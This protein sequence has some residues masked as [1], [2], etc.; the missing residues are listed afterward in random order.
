[1]ETRNGAGKASQAGNRVAQQ[2]CCIM[3][4]PRSQLL[5]SQP[6]EVLTT[7]AES[8]EGTHKPLSD[9]AKRGC[10]YCSAC[11]PVAATGLP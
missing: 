7:K 9:R 10:K 11:I 1:M 6:S 8:L 3:D 4:H 5:H 2:L